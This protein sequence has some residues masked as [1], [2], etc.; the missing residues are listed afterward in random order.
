MYYTV[1]DFTNKKK[2]PYFKNYAQGAYEIFL[3]TL[4]VTWL[5]SVGAICKET[6]DIWCDNDIW[7]NNNYN[8]SVYLPPTIT[9][10]DEKTSKKEVMDWLNISSKI[11]RHEQN[12]SGSIIIKILDLGWLKMKIE[13][14][15]KMLGENIGG[16]NGKGNG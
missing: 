14:P 8:E 10:F 13:L 2:I 3:G 9:L 11:K 6:Y 1:R 12:I 16:Q 5:N 7:Y 4:N 15:E